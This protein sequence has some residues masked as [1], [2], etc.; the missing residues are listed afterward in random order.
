MYNNMPDCASLAHHV[1]LK[2]DNAGRIVDIEIDP[3]RAF[4]TDIHGHYMEREFLNITLT[5]VFHADFT[6]LQRIF[7]FTKRIDFVFSAMNIRSR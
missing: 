2:T 5:V 4:I 1:G 3:S 7:F 6:I